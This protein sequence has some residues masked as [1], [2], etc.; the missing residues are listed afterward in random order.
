[1][2]RFYYFAA[3]SASG[4]VYTV[5]H[6]AYPRVPQAALIDGFCAELYNAIIMALLL[7]L[8]RPNERDKN[9]S[10]GAG[11]LR[12]FLH[13]NCNEQLIQTTKTHSKSLESE[14]RQ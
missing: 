13:C 10:G 2:A 1:M 3:V 6:I 7:L 4:A 14:N 12:N 5:S 8:Q 11:I 9:Y